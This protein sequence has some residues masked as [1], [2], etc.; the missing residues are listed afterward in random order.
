[1][2]VETLPITLGEKKT[3][4]LLKGVILLDALILL[5]AFILG[6]VNP[7]SYALIFCLL[8]MTLCLLVYEKR[9]LYP[10][11]RMEYLVE[12]NFYL[13]GLLGLLWQILS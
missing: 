3:L 2:G 5:V 11:T 7:F 9:W 13:A 10:G 6:L 1:V 12:G 4:M 8:T